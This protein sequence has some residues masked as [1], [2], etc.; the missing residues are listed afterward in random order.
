MSERE[1]LNAHLT[2]HRTADKSARVRLNALVHPSPDGEEPISHGTIAID[3]TRPETKSEKV[4]VGSL[5]E[6]MVGMMKNASFASPEDRAEHELK[7]GVEA[8]RVFARSARDL[9]DA[10]FSATSPEE[11]NRHLDS[12]AKHLDE[13]DPT[14]ELRKDVFTM[15]DAFGLLHVHEESPSDPS[16]S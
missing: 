14:R 6:W 10:V 2:V 3:F 16:V 12:F 1:T 13:M 9:A 4:G 8:V 7:I 5:E 11:A 15:L